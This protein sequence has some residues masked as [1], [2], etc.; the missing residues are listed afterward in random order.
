MCDYKTVLAIQDYGRINIKLRGVME[1]KKISRYQ[2]SKLCGTR[3]EV[4]NKWYTGTVERIDSDV[5]ARICF[6]LVCRVEDVI[7]YNEQ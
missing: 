7:E 3:F 5:L 1:Q 2:L 4:I 6:S